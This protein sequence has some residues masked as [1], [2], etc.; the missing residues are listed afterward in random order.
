[1]LNRHASYPYSQ[2]L[3]LNQA[4]F[5]YKGLCTQSLKINVSSS[6][7]LNVMEIREDTS[8]KLSRSER[9]ENVRLK[10]S[11]LQKS[12]GSYI[13]VLKMHIQD[14]KTSFDLFAKLKEHPAQKGSEDEGEEVVL[15]GSESRSEIAII[16]IR[17][18]RKSKLSP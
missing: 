1:M 13:V 14:E 7:L 6:I 8:S 11:V 10:I 18:I 4:K 15:I 17:E 2:Y 12:E 16:V 9:Y 3:K 5:T